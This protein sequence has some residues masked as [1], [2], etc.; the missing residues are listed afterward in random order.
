[1]VLNRLASLYHLK[2]NIRAVK[3]SIQDP[4]YFIVIG[5]KKNFYHIQKCDKYATK[6]HA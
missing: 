2:I 1:M 4:E 5:L 6:D 3:A